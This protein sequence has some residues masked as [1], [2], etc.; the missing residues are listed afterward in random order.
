MSMDFMDP[1]PIPVAPHP[2]PSPW[3]GKSEQTDQELGH[4][5]SRRVKRLTGQV[6][7][8]EEE[9]PG[10]AAAW[11][12]ADRQ[13]TGKSKEPRISFCDSAYTQNHYQQDSF[14]GKESLPFW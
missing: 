2:T 13:L 1:K 10:P 7:R 6:G 5:E 8:S 12:W 11:E 14:T 9:L 3:R 4:G